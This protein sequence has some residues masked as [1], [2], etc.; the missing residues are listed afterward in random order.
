MNLFNNPFNILGVSTRDNRIK[1]MEAAAVK[2]LQI[3]SDICN[4]ARVTLTHPRNRLK[5][6][7][8]W[9]PDLSKKIYDKIIIYINSDQALPEILKVEVMNESPI[10][11][12]N[13]LAYELERFNF[14]DIDD[15]SKK[16]I[17]IDRL[18]EL[19]N[20]EDVRLQINEE[21]MASGFTA[22]ETVNNIEKEFNEHIHDISGNINSKIKIMG[23]E[24]CME[25][26]TM[27]ADK[28]IADDEYEYGRIIST[29]IDWYEAYIHNWL[30]E[31]KDEILIQTKE[32]LENFNSS[33][34]EYEVELIIVK[35]Q[36][37]D[38]LAQPL[39][40]SSRA[41]GLVHE[42]SEELATNL[43]GASI[44][45]HNEYLDIEN[46]KRL[47]VALREVFAELDEFTENVE[48]DEKIF[49][50]NRKINEE[51]DRLKKQEL[52]RQEGE[53]FSK[54]LG[55]AIRAA[56]FIGIAIM[57]IAANNSDTNNSTN[58]SKTGNNSSAAESQQGSSNNVE[59]STINDLESEIGDMES[60]LDSL[61]STL[62]QLESDVAYY[63]EEYNNSG[64]DSDYEI[65]SSAYD[66]Y[67][68]YIN[69]Y[70]TL[71]SDY[72]DKINEYNLLVEEY[73]S[74]Q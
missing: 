8:A 56:I 18:A 36:N 62:V 55:Y 25:I 28:C 57:I 15:S 38:K 4:N 6:E 73:N 49:D 74:S 40:I 48:N 67:D 66:D 65:Y 71:Y 27:I 10:T 2:G 44:Y 3:D 72:E 58:T 54:R 61:N 22:I 39:Q 29:I 30:E 24:K 53:K 23:K 5:A 64:S 1:I 9:L 31:G 52:I 20:F 26:V 51:N 60:E 43:R 33:T 7:I 32:V 42:M 69:Q 21:R 14:E 47:L 12:L 46:S 68:N 37:W 34:I 19:V 17:E 41:K 50:S 11:Q 63:E 35:L 45:I 16:I 59:L 13:I 70:N